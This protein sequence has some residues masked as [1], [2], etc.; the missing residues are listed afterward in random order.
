[1]NDLSYKIEA[2]KKQIFSDLVSR[3]EDKYG[4]Y[5]RNLRRLKL[6]PLFHKGGILL[7]SQYAAMRRIDDIVD[8][9]IE[10]SSSRK[11][12]V[13]QRINFVLNPENPKDDADY[14]MLHCFSLAHKLKL[15]ISEETLD[16]LKSM[17]FDAK[18]V[19]KMI[20]FP[21]EE[22]RN[23]F[24]LLDIRGTIKGALKVFG[25]N[26]DKFELLNPL[27]EASRIFYDLRDFKEDIE[28]GYI[29]ISQ[30]DFSRYGMN[31]ENLSV[32]SPSVKRWFIDQSE[33]GLSLLEEHRKIMEKNIFKQIG[34]VLIL[35]EFYVRPAKNYFERI[36][37]I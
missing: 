30:E 2:I 34:E 24:Y 33:R 22:L 35:P 8:G 17:L 18:R 25:E 31:L 36:L 3:D 28:H 11:E 13:E 1:M 12:Y 21:E 14:L 5:I 32:D 15:D 37:S 4:K 26:S 7:E 20:I 19:D 10:F 23:H 16:I 6:L 29:N 27:G 9:D